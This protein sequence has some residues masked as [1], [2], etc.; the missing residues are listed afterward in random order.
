M[1]VKQSPVDSH[2]K[3]LVMQKMFLCHDVMIIL[4]KTDTGVSTAPILEKIYFSIQIL[5]I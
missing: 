5:Q 4:E 1:R 2:H 3:W